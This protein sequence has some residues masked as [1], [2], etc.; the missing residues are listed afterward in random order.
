MKKP[1]NIAYF[2]YIVLFVAACVVPGAML[3]KYRTELPPLR[4]EDGS[5][6]KDW[7]T[8]FTAFVSDHFGF[9]DT[10]VTANGHLQAELLHT[11]AEE[12]V[13]I[14]KDGW[15]YYTPTVHD[16]L[17]D[18]TISDAG[19]Q[20][21]VY[22]LTMMQDYVTQHGGTFITALVPNK[23]TVYPQYMP[24]NYRQS[25]VDGNLE[26]LQ[27]L[28]AESSVT[29]ADLSQALT[30]AAA[31]SAEPIYHK[32]DTHWNNTGALI[33]YRTILEAAGVPYEAYADLTPSVEMSWN[34]DLQGMLF[35]DSGVLDAQQVYP[36]DFTYTYQ[37]H[38]RNTDDISIRTVCPTGT[39]SLLMFR[40]SFGAAIIPY[41]SEH[42]QTATYSR[43]RPEPL[44]QIETAPV[45]LVVLE[46]VERNLAWLQQ[47]APLHAAPAVETVPQAA[48]TCSASL[49]SEQN[50]RFLQLYGSIAFPEMP[51]QAA[52]YYITLTGADGVS[53]S[54]LAYHC[55]EA[56]K[57]GE[58][59]I[60]D[61]GYSLYIP[62]TDL[63]PQSY[64]VTLTV[65]TESTCTGCSLGA[66]TIQ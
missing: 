31:D 13:I 36:I 47:E 39:G 63:T 48:D 2:L 8:Q 45:D 66:V 37:G 21:I 28:L 44:S 3:V 49:C 46:I 26:R 52:D 32:Q 51:E 25:G 20:N 43:A 40:D 11:S 64:A 55:Y 58:S 34:G 9:H 60:L 33:G 23:N 61:N 14:G 1:Q 5:F 19:L 41:L 38:Y 7:N 6:N 12:D 62:L 24:Y 59:E 42:F 53:H 30:Q 10:L 18:P 4:T 16:F 15:L 50:G 54:Y 27:A 35:P 22:N 17:G 56:K 65:Q 57:F 29:Y